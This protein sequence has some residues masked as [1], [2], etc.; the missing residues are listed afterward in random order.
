MIQAKHGFTVL[1]LCLL[2]ALGLMA[3]GATAAQAENE[4]LLL[5]PGK[6][7]A[8]EGVSK[9]EGTGEGVGT[10]RLIVP[11]KK[12]EIVC[13]KVHVIIIIGPNF[14]ILIL[15]FLE[16][17]TWTIKIGAGKHEYILETELKNCK[18]PGEEIKLEGS[19]KPLLHNSEAYLDTEG[20]GAEKVFAKLQYEAGKGC[21]LPT[22]SIKVLGEVAIQ[23][24]Q[25]NQSP[26]HLK[27]SPTITLLLQEAGLPGFKLFYGLNE[28]YVEGE[29]TAKITSPEKFTNAAFGAH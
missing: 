29:M 17:K 9:V 27:L 2:V 21:V 28:A 12:I 14:W 25:V 6:T 26:Q 13:K 11:S 3:F 20:S 24:D 16:C 23:I 22:E 4:F 15:I 8:E 18:L 1:G 7:F 10:F 19:S 5:N